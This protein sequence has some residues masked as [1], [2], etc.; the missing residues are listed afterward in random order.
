MYFP[1]KSLVISDEYLTW[2]CTVCKNLRFSFSMLLYF[3]KSL[4]QVR[5]VRYMFLSPHR[6]GPCLMRLLVKYMPWAIFW[7]LYLITA[8]CPMQILGYSIS[9]F[10]YFWPKNC[11]NEINS[12]KTSKTN[13]FGQFWKIASMKFT[14]MKL[15]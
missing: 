13:V 11:S 7:L 3:S 6:E 2:I 10:A 5:W 9:F 12:P 4:S 8:I 1:W 14:L 15:P